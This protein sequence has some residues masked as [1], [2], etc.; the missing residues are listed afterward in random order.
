MKGM[1]S[2]SLLIIT[3]LLILAIGL[4]CGACT[5][6]GA[7]TTA[8]S[9]GTTASSAGTTANST[10]S[11]TAS[12]EPEKT[13][14]IGMVYSL[15]T[16]FYNAC[17]V[18]AKDLEK[19]IGVKVIIEKPEKADIGIQ[20]KT[21][22]NFVSQGV[23]G[24]IVNV[25]GEGVTPAIDEAISKGIP[26]VTMAIDAPNSKRIAYF[27]SDQ[28]KYGEDQAKYIAKLL[29]EKGDILAIGGVPTSPDQISR[30]EAFK[31]Q[32][33]SYPNMKILDVQFGNSDPV[34]TLAI[35]ES[36]FQ[37]N[38][39]VNGIV[40]FNASSGAPMLTALKQFDKDNII[41]AVADHDNPDVIMGMKE[42]IIEASQVQRPYKMAYEAIKCLYN[43]A[44]D[45]TEP[46]KQINYIDTIF[47]TPQDLSNYDADN[48]RINEYK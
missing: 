22:E 25:V 3:V 5:G 47:L 20:I 14:T 19:E 12:T 21:I 34:K 11:T 44:K 43:L 33:A 17:D 6:T 39:N 4:T 1:R 38:E 8:S 27:G 23:D 18:A 10:T 46:A 32:I 7:S 40:A 31:K 15:A 28:S 26:V 2:K 13:I 30:S 37:A 35:L 41:A 36:M 42:G 24:I 45:G 48:K 16:P 9:A 29:G